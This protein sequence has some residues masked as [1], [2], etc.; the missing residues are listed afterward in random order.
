MNIIQQPDSLSFSL[1]LKDFI[2]SSDSQVSFVLRQDGIDVLSQLYD[3][4]ANGNITINL[5]DVI[6]GR[7]TTVFKDLSDPYEQ[8]QLTAEFIAFIDGTEIK[9]K[10][11]RGGVDRLAD[12]ATNFLTQ[13]FLTWQPQI[14]PVTYYSPEFLT[15]YATTESTVKLKAYFTSD[16][17]EVTSQEIDIVYIPKNKVYTVP[18]QY[19]IIAGLLNNRLPSY[20]DVWVENSFGYRLTYVQRYYASDMASEQEQWILFENSL[21]GIDTFRAHGNMTFTGEHTHNLAEIDEV[22]N[23]YRVDTERKFQKN[24]GFLDDTQRKW[25]LDFFPSGQK[26]IYIG[27]YFRQIVVMESNVTYSAKELPS[28]YTFTYKYADAK[29]L[30]NLPRT[31]VPADVLHI[32]VPEIGSFTVPPRL[33]EF[34]HLPLSE[35]ALFP[36][37]N[38]YSEEWTTTTIA[39]IA[40]YLMSIMVGVDGGILSEKQIRELIIAIGK[41]MFLRKDQSDTTQFLTRFMAGITAG[42][43]QEGYSGA[44]IDKEGNAELNKLFVRLA[45]T[46]RNG[47][48]SEEFISGFPGGKGWALFWREVINAAGAV[49][50]KAAME[51]DDLTI[52]GILRVYEFII[53]QMRGENGTILTT[54]MMKV[55]SVDIEN[56]IIYLDTENGILF[57]PFRADDYIEVKHYSTDE[58]YSKHYEFQ[59]DKSHIGNINDGE[60]RLDYITY[61][62]FIGDENL[63]TSRD[64]LTRVDSDDIDR[65]GILKQTA[66]EE[67]SPYLDVLYGLK[68]DPENAVKSRLGRLAG[69]ITYFW[70][71][72]KGYGLFSDNAYLLGDFRLR[73]GDDVRTYFE[74]LEG[75]F[76][77]AMQCVINTMT[78]EDNFLKNATFQN[79]MENWERESEIFFYDFG[80]Y[81]L[82]MGTGF[83]AEK[84]ILAD[85]A[86]FDGRFMLRIYRSHIWQL[87]EHITKPA[88]ESRIYMTIK[89][90]CE[91]SGTLSMG[92]TGTTSYTEQKLEA[93]PGF[94]TF[95]VSGT[96]D[97]TGNF[98]LR[99]TGDIYIEQLAI[100][101]HPLE[102][103][104]KEVS[105]Q[106]KQQ[107]NE[108]SAVVKEVNRISG[109]VSE[110]GWITQETGNQ[111]WAKKELEDGNTLISYIN[112]AAVS[113]TIHSS[114]INLEGAVTMTAL[115]NE[116]KTK[117]N[118][119]I[120]RSDLGSLAF[121]D[122]VE[123][124]QLGSTI[125]VGGYLNT[126]LIKV[127]RIDADAGF[128]GGFTLENGRLIWTRSDYFGGTSRSL[129]LGSG[130][131]KEGVVNITFNAATDG[132]F[133]V[134]A[135]G[136]NIGGSAAIYGSSNMYS[137]NYPDNYVYAGFFDGNVRVLGDISANG[138]YVKGSDGEYLPVVSD[139]WFY[140]YKNVT[141]N[142]MRIHV[143]KGL[144]VY[145]EG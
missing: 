46:F 6:H 85:L 132:R 38:P 87:N 7:L 88:P 70:G 40:T 79:D 129:K 117:V 75:L 80:G 35:G 101:N 4:S 103:Y 122:A 24:T 106:F 19:S 31:D 119:A 131:A 2:I 20:Y 29:P 86:S 83:Y 57:N 62:N 5:K 120:A 28:S 44:S 69:I 33:A 71:Q 21:G 118:N 123:A 140:G 32:S 144:I 14:K 73:T 60:K 42:K 36:V 61:K 15:Y 99:F 10:V 64:V 47:L 105:S 63:I 127:R 96:W 37:Q 52:R 17:G 95:E 112:Q 145:M 45:A 134:A 59:I 9:F 26:Y 55:H 41:E 133:G 136:A 130:T 143:V 138:F 66:V 90:H 50:K 114:K 104:Q 125:V 23:E 3:P 97:G 84:Q 11:V 102:D 76:Q 137:P 92:F 111:L 82:D 43:Y 124:A 1:N 109:E 128:V 65:K 22:T 8:T 115:D 126:D 49:E 100:T 81:L 89:Y 67:G 78:E 68:T 141:G 53:S 12:S 39:A 30:L 25:L 16:S 142:V 56:K 58:R 74:V 121:K 116:L 48:S 93:Q 94:H 18:M 91:E 34:P 113:T 13:N 77:S 107:A 27:N 54:D 110:G 108:I 135:M 98:E 51:L 72:L 139:S